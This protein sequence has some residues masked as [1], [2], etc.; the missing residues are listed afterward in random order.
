MSRL[1]AIAALRPAAA[2]AAI[3][4][5]KKA[6]RQ[7]PSRHLEVRPE[8]MQE[9]TMR[10]SLRTLAAVAA[11]AT[12]LCASDAQAQSFPARP[13]KLIV[14]YAPGGSTDQLARA[15]AERLG[16]ALGQPVVVENKPGANTI[17]AAEA[18]AK[19][20]PDGYTLFMGS[21]A[22]L[23]VNRLLYDKL[24]YDPKRDFA[25]VTLV[26]QSPLVMEVNADVPA[27]TVKEFVALAKA[28]P[29]SINFASVGNG[30]PLHLA[31]ELFNS[32]A[33]ID[34]VHVPFNGSAPALTALL[35]G[36]VQL[37]YDVI[38][39]SQPHIKAGKLRALAVTGTKRVPVLP[40][41]PTIAESGYPGYEAGIWF[42]MVVPRAT[43]DAIVQR[44]NAET[45]RILRQPDMKARFDGLALEL[46]PSAP[47]DVQQLADKEQARWE[48]VI[49]EKN[50]RLEF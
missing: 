45:T 6:D 20:A 10:A 7:G 47:G 1:R 18:A 15:V 28:K 43:P 34:T 41:V 49:R 42:A 3:P 36:H 13:L 40:D 31:G 24:P 14:P 23:A 21:S 44:L 29:G 5:G 50:I 35:G 26:A 33:G 2:G 11:A 27:K 16:Q 9:R 4:D 25:G 30:N 46:I 19:S 12:L 37:M 39:T 17:I 38:L 48:R 32:V 22:S 8:V